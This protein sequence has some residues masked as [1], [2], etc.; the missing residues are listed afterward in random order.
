MKKIIFLA[1]IVMLLMSCEKE[2]KYCGK[3]VSKFKTDAGYKVS[4]HPHV[5]FYCDSLK[6]NVDVE[7][8][9]NCYA[10]AFV[11]KEVCFLLRSDQLEN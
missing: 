4:A 7:V 3:V 11:G 9:W 5:Q 8:T 2:A 6:R 1:L 10:N